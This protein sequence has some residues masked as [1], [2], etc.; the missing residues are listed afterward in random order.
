MPIESAE[1]K[2]GLFA[3]M[4]ERAKNISR[5]D[6]YF[7]ASMGLVIALLLLPLLHNLGLPGIL[8]SYGLSFF[9][10]ACSLVVL[11]PF[12]LLMLAYVLAM[13]PFHHVSAAQLSR[14][15]VIGCFNVALNAAIFNLL[16]LF[17]GI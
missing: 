6:A 8:A 13:L 3:H 1:E 9:W 16:I 5:Y 12:G 11:A 2:S 7:I 10:V 14:Y 4:R 17:S 15:A